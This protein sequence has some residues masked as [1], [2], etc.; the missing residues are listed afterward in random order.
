MESIN[1]GLQQTNLRDDNDM[2]VDTPPPPPVSRTLEA[3]RKALAR[4]VSNVHPWLHMI[5]H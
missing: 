1:T 3:K 5:F 4:F 2:V